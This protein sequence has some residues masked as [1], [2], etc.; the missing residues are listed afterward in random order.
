MVE[1]KLE[2]FEIR[3]HAERPGKWQIYYQ[4]ASYSRNQI[5]SWYSWRWAAKRDVRRL[6]RRNRRRICQVER[7]QTRESYKIE[8]HWWDRIRR[9]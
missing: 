3:P 1:F 7:H 2:D 9:V 5:D 4:D 6:V 8:P